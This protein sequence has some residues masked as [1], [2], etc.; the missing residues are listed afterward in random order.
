VIVIG[1]LLADNMTFGEQEFGSDGGLQGSNVLATRPLI[2]DQ[3]FKLAFDIEFESVPA[4][5]TVTLNDTDPVIP[6]SNLSRQYGKV[7]TLE[8]VAGV[9]VSQLGPK[10]T[11]DLDEM[12]IK[13]Q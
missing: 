2:T 6:G 5:L 11:L 8:Q 13:A 12:R 10:L 7:P 1:T 3:W 4:K 9:Y